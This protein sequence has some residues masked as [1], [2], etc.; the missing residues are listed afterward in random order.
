MFNDTYFTNK[1][2]AQ[3]GGVSL[4]NMNQLESF[5]MSLIDWNLY[6]SP[7]QFALY[8]RNIDAFVPSP[9]GSEISSPITNSPM[10]SPTVLAQPQ[11]LV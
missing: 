5:F 2:I 8:E 3:V 10:G 11:P 6:I 9:T 7:E 4:S 1:Y